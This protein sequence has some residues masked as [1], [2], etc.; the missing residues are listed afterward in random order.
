MKIITIICTVCLFFAGCASTPS[1]T[2]QTSQNVRDRDKFI[3]IEVAA[4][5]TPTQAAAD[6]TLVA[7]VVAIPNTFNLPMA[8]ALPEADLKQLAASPAFEDA[9]YAQSV[10]ESHN[11]MRARDAAFARQQTAEQIAL[12]DSPDKAKVYATKGRP[13]R[14]DV[15]EI[16]GLVWE[17]WWYDYDE[18]PNRTSLYTFRDGKLVSHSTQDH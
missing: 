5:V 17:T 10:I 12:N 18:V 8:L 7:R 9:R 16:D 11:S 13:T 2:S 4:G 6:Y 15:T 1:Q 14:R 3:A